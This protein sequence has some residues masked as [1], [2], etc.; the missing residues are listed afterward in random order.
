MSRTFNWKNKKKCLQSCG[1][2][3]EHFLSDNY[4]VHYRTLSVNACFQN[5]IDHARFVFDLVRFDFLLELK[6]S[7]NTRFLGSTT[8][9]RETVERGQLSADN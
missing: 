2:R 1:D 7:L 3:S 9:E 5:G 8:I 6:K 4:I